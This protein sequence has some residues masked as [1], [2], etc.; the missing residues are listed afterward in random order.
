MPV[1]WKYTNDNGAESVSLVGDGI[2]T[3]VSGSHPKF[4]QLRDYLTA[5]RDDG[6]EPDPARLRELTDLAAQ[7]AVTLGR[8]TE[9]VSFDGANL[10]FDGDRVDNSLSRHIVRMIKDGD[11]QYGRWVR[12]MENLAEN[13]SLLSRLH[14]FTWLARRDFALTPEGHLLGYKGVGSDGLSVSSGTASV[15]GTTHRGRI[16]NPVGAVVEMPRLRVNP[17][18]RNACS[19]GLHVGTFEYAAGFGQRLLLVSV[20]PRDVV[21]VPRDCG[22]QKMRVCRYTVLSVHD[23]PGPVTTPSWDCDD[24]TAFP[25]DPDGEFDG[26]EDQFGDDD[27]FDDD[28]E[29]REREW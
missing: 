3:V 12:F 9:R 4:G 17:D 21:S 11:E 1:S 24:G 14:L 13:P 23:V 20:N 2:S 19:V 5:T 22:F 7:V 27:G 29:R 15:D 28:D 10:R 18:R 6:A 26:D 16:P 8:L 25:D